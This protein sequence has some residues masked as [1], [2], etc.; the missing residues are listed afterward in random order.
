MYIQK[1]LVFCKFNFNFNLKFYTN[2]KAAYLKIL[3]SGYNLI[4]KHAY[5]LRFKLLVVNSKAPCCPID[6]KNYCINDFCTRSIA[7][8]LRYTF[9]N[10]F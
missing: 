7:Y 2:Q 8:I 6:M 4:A 9:L 5:I 1:I 10:Y 3:R